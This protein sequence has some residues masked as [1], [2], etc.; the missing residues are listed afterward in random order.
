M[1]KWLMRFRAVLLAVVVLAVTGCQP[2]ETETP[3]TDIPSTDSKP[4][5]RDDAETV[6]T[7][8]PI[9]IE[10]SETLKTLEAAPTTIPQVQLPQ[11]LKDTCLVAVGDT[12][13]TGEVL[14]IDGEKKAV[15]DLL[16]KKGTVVFFWGVGG[17]EIAEKMA[18]QALAD[19]DGGAPAAYGGQGLG[20]IS[21]TPNAPPEEAKEERGAVD[22]VS[23]TIVSRMEMSKRVKELLGTLKISYPIL[24]DPGG[25]YFAKVATAKLPRVY[26]LDA[27]G[28]IAW[29]DVGFSESSRE[30][31]KRTLEFMFGGTEPAKEKE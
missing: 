15:A 6:V 29:F 31:L 8:E 19:L 2:K 12:L 23:A 10:M 20:V 5:V 4:P 7:K 28:K 17:S 26:V 22:N 14:T 21:I 25:T 18:V 11:A 30:D 1:G 13:P 24:L 9:P 27:A 16:G 3:S